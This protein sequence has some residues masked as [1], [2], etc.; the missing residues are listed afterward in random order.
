MKLAHFLKNLFDIKSIPCLRHLI[1]MSKVE[2]YINIFF[3][4]SPKSNFFLKGVHDFDLVAEI[5]KYLLIIICSDNS[6]LSTVH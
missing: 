1:E 5:N 4:V 6:I 2:M 3:F